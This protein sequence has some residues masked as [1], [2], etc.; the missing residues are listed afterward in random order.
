M[1]I[2]PSKEQYATNRGE[3]SGRKPAKK[4]NPSEEPRVGE[5]IDSRITMKM[6]A[7]KERFL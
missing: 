7:G 5:V 4:S 1:K 3:A 6:Q 2:Q